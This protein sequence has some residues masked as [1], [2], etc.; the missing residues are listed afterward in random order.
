MASR[1]GGAL[2]LVLRAGQKVAQKGMI[3]QDGDAITQVLL[4]QLA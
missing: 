3:Q 1:G 4:R 2:V